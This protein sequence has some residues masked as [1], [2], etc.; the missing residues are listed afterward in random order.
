M[1]W[2]EQFIL[3][4]PYSLLRRIPYGWLAIA[5]LRRWEPAFSGIILA[6]ALLS[7]LMMVWQT[8][9][10]QAKIKREFSGGKAEPFTDHP[11]AARTFQVRNL[12]LV[13]AGSAALGWLMN[14]SFNLGVLQWALLLAGI[15]LFYRDSLL[16]GAAVTY[17]VTDRGISVRYVPGVADHRLFFKFIE[18]RQAVRTKPPERIPL[19]WYMLTPRNHPQ[20]GLLLFAV[21]RDGFSK[22]IQGEVFLAPTDI[23]AFLAALAGRV[24]VTEEIPKGTG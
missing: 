1:K 24:A 17:M 15:M 4:I 2:L 14:G 16:F 5:F 9:A 20:E 11:H 7:V 12:V 6:V 8:R 18:I 19:R 21:R 23:N 13:L 3:D 22:Q 10:W